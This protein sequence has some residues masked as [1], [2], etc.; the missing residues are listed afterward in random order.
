MK[1]IKYTYKLLLVLPLIFM[2]SCDN[3]NEMIDVITQT[4][5]TSENTVFIETDAVSEVGMLLS[6][7][8][9]QTITVGVN[10]A[11]STD[12]T[13]GFAVMKDGGVAVDGVDYVLS[14]A[15]IAA[16]DNFG[17]SDITFLT[18][19]TFEVTISSSSLSDL[20]IVNNKA[21]FLVPL[22][23]TFT[24]DWDDSFYDYDIFL[25]DGMQA[26]FTDIYTNGI[27]DGLNLLGLSNG[28][29]NSE[30]FKAIPLEGTNYLYIEDYW[31]DNASIPVILTIEVGGDV[32]VFNLT[33]DMDKFGLS[34][35]TTIGEDGFPVHTFTGL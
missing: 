35:E 34:I 19:G 10:N 16:N 33:M 31:N 25:F 26:G 20:E 32:Q 2:V 1:N 29:S 6:D 27:P 9:P 15:V 8:S 4:T 17:T 3:S 14:D 12:V 23:V 7:L 30:T 24:L 28:I 13:V 18:N 22:Q 11:T 5:T 21:I